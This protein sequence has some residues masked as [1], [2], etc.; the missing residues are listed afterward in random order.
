MAG[1]HFF[2]FISARVTTGMLPVMARGG[3]TI[4]ND[5]GRERLL[6]IWLLG[7][8]GFSR[9]VTFW[10]PL[11]CSVYIIVCYESFARDLLAGPL[12][13]SD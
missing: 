10:I 5:M 7:S 8:F 1:T 4:H 13:S 6:L 9:S 11:K 12:I 3:I 2:P